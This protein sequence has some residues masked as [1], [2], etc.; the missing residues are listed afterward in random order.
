MIFTLSPATA[1]KASSRVFLY[2]LIT[3]SFWKIESAV[4]IAF[5]PSSLT[6]FIGSIHKETAIGGINFDSV[7]YA[8]TWLN[9]YSNDSIFLLNFSFLFIF[10]V[11][12]IN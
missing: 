9:S 2:V 11:N 7:Q 12:L 4:K 10:S 1:S 5:E 6:G 3:V 8:F